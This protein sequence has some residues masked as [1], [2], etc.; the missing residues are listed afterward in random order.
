MFLALSP[1]PDVLFYSTVLL[2]VY[3]STQSHVRLFNFLEVGD[4]L[5]IVNGGKDLCFQI[6]FAGRF[7][8]HGA[9]ISLQFFFRTVTIKIYLSHCC[10]ADFI[11]VFRC[12]WLL[13]SCGYK[14][15]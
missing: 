15:Q 2:H 12:R 11:M 3:C 9:F 10:A 6:K 4:T 8:N 7:L 5:F 13:P 14:P 1:Q